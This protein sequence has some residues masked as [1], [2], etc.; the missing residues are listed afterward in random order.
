MGK[1]FRQADAEATD[2]YF[3]GEE[4][5]E[6]RDWIRVRSSITNAEAHQLLGKAPTGERDLIGGFEFIERVF[7]KVIVAWS[8]TDKNGDP[9]APTVENFRTMDAA[10]ARHI[11]D[12]VA[13][14]LSRLLGREVEKLEGESS[15]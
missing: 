5:E 6:D 8:L 13:Q 7:D 2:V 1:L 15:S 14:H 10:G 4:D 11:E 9:L 3:F 12:K